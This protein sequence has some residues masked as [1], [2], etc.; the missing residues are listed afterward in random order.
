MLSVSNFI[1]LPIMDISKTLNTNKEDPLV[2]SELRYRRLFETAQD[3]I[4]LIDFDTGMILDVNRFLIDLLG[5]SKDDFLKKYLWEVGVFKDIA[6]SKDNFLTLQKEGYVRF[7]DLPLETKTGERVDVEV[8]AN[9][10]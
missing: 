2:V 10:Y 8:V 1:S 3:G 6:A 4:L 7:E 9:A 5:Y